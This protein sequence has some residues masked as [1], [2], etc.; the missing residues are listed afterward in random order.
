L[1]KSKTIIISRTDKI[2]DVILTLP[3]AGIL[4]KNYPEARL[5]FLGSTYTKPVVSTCEHIDEFIDFSELKDLNKN[6]QIKKLEAFNADVILHVYPNKQIAW[7]A[8]KAGIPIRIGTSHRI[9]NLTSC[10][11]LVRLNRRNSDLH[12]AQLNI[13][14][15]KPLDLDTEIPIEQIGSLYGFT[16][17]AE[18]DRNINKILAKDKIRIIL[19]PKSKGSAREWGLK[20]FSELIEN[21]PQEKYQ[22]FITGTSEEGLLMREFLDSHSRK[23]TNMTGK[24][25]LD[26]LFAFIASADALVAASTGPLH[27]AAALGKVAIGLYPPIR[28]MHPGRWGCIGQNAHVMVK[29]I[30]CNHCRKA[31][32]CECIESISPID[33]KKILDHITK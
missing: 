21:L 22:I 15:L 31:D 26:Q 19:H 24:L 32:R 7:L 29:D 9:Y 28:P 17:I 12:E 3:L 18:L 33:I 10:N 14:L 6:D 5:L 20:N 4:R 13:K 1:N 30:E 8:K 11:R 2:G 23:I 16:R 27:M 25:S